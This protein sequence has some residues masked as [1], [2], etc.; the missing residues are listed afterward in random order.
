MGVAGEEKGR[1]CWW[2]RDSPCQAEGIL[3]ES[4]DTG[5]SEQD[6]SFLLLYFFYGQSYITKFCILTIF[7][8]MLQW[9]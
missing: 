1:E 9:Y 7:K 6:A 2:K 4:V 5:T 8:C 3:S